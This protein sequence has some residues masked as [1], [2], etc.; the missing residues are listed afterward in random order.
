MIYLTSDTHFGHEKVAKIRG[1]ERVEEHDYWLIEIWNSVVKLADTVIHLGDFGFGDKL[2]LRQIA[3]AL[4]GHIIMVQGNHDRSPTW[5]TRELGIPCFT[6]FSF[7]YGGHEFTCVHDPLDARGK[8]GQIVLH[9]HTHGNIDGEEFVYDDGCRV[10]VGWDPH[11]KP[12][13]IT[14]IIKEISR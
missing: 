3:Q 6:K 13:K 12:I 7:K 1:Y 9:G 10:H 5:I 4:H 8:E 11:R 2:Q 14:R